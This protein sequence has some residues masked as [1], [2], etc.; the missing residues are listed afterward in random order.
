MSYDSEV[1]SSYTPN[2]TLLLFFEPNSFS[3]L[4][5]KMAGL[6]SEIITNVT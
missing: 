3:E 6:L 1:L 2:L 5:Q 4:T